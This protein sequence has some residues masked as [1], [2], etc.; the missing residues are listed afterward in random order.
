MPQF[1]MGKHGMLTKNIIV[2]TEKSSTDPKIH[3][4]LNKQCP[5]WTN[6]QGTCHNA[7]TP[8]STSHLGIHFTHESHEDSPVGIADGGIANEV[9][10]HPVLI[11]PLAQPN[12]S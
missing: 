11:S 5:S 2:G 8:A 12:A 10:A 4:L 7:E 3:M 9:C 6:F 1:F